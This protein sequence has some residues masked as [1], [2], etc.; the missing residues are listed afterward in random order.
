MTAETAPAR[1]LL[2]EDDG[3]QAK[4]Y[5]AFLG[6]GPYHLNHVDTGQ[7]A[8][9]ELERRVPDAVLLDLNLPDMDGLDVLRHISGAGMPTA[10]VVITA[11]GS[12][13]NAVAAMRHGAFDFVAKPFDGKRLIVTL[14]NALEHQRLSRLVETYR[15]DFDRDAFGGFVG[16]SLPMQ[17]VYSII[18]N[19]ARSKATVFITGESGTG[20]EVGAVAIHKQS[21]R[22]GGPFIA[23]NCGAIPKDLTESEIFGHV[24]GAFT[25]AVRDREGAALAAHGG[26]LF[27]DEICDMDLALQAKFLRFVQTGTFQRV[28]DSRTQSVDVRFVCATNRDP[29]AEVEAGRFR[30][31]LYYRLHVIPIHLPPLRERD[32]DVL[33]I[34]R[35]FLA[36][37]AAEEGK[38]FTD[39]EPEVTDLMLGYGWPGNVREVQNVVRHA[40]VLNDGPT[41]TPE[42]LPPSIAAG[43]A[44]GTT[45]RVRRTADVAGAPA[46]PS[47][48][49]DGVIRP[50]AEVERETIERAIALCDGNVPQAAAH[51]GISASTIYRKRATWED[52]DTAA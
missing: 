39:F 47:P 43:A 20:K 22:A 48:G 6:D 38:T 2:V 50:L 35:T 7:A 23:I 27:L 29:L 45:A 17:A 10:V 42:M 5:T 33:A 30:E 28:G 24:K 15:N 32:D 44:P 16:S 11:D 51:L 21:P 9:A 26:T 25:G 36:E 13:D 12:V 14:G 3:R 31:D 8:L 37:Y 34:A 46:P 19:A 41:V 49:E 52:G 1:V 4:L 18:E 40:V